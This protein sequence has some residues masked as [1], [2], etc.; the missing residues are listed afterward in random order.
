MSDLN[1]KALIEAFLQGQGFKDLDD[2]M[3][4]NRASAK[5][6]QDAVGQLGYSIENLQNTF[7]GLF[8]A[9]KVFSFL[10]DG[11]EGFART[12]RQWTGITAQIKALG[13]E[14]GSLSEN[15]RE[16][17]SS[18]SD[19]S[20]ILDDDLIPAFGRLLR[21]TDSVQSAQGF[22]KIASRF[23]ANGIG[24]VTTNAERLSIAFQTGTTKSLKD[25]GVQTVDAEGNATKFADAIKLIV[26]RANQFPKAADDAQAKID[27]WRKVMDDFG[28]SL[29]AVTNAILD[30]VIELNK[31]GGELDEITNKGYLDSI[32]TAEQKAADL[33]TEAIAS[34]LK[35]RRHEAAE[36]SL[37]AAVLREAK[38]RQ[39]QIDTA[40]AKAG[41]EQ[42]AKDA[43][44]AEARKVAAIKKLDQDYQTY[45]SGVHKNEE[46]STGDFFADI[47]R[48]AKQSASEQKKLYPDISKDW[49]KLQ[50]DITREAKQ[51]AKDRIDIAQREADLDLAAKQEILAASAGFV[52]AAFGQS[53]AAAIAEGGIHL[54][55]AILGITDK[56]AWNPA[57]EAVL[58]GL[59]SATY[60]AQIAQIE[61]AP[62]PSGFDDPVNDAL[63]ETFGQKW[64]AD[65]F[66]R[67]NSGF[68][69][70]L[71]KLDFSGGGGSTTVNN[72]RNSSFSPN[73]STT[74]N[75]RG[76]IFVRDTNGIKQFT[77]QQDEVRRR[78]L[79]RARISRA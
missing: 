17:I 23:A 43:I 39:R 36:E 9:S 10:K 78:I 49:E 61:S 28:D 45:L 11:F 34:N 57:V 26:D 79:M 2:A 4:K 72:T 21:A 18:L 59:A 65:L 25:F 48:A 47:L 51:G 71:A 31:Y 16:F 5:E 50:D 19:E 69:R 67:V 6:T 58:I 15:V 76:P 22:L 38:E 40:D 33:R 46:K 53:K 7:L 77:R 13:D 30:Q 27:T 24:D 1:V 63:A 62:S 37:I 60:A 68:E 12:E 29:S 32:K 64:A 52:S 70:S 56:W 54:A 73:Y 44:A 3:A 14:S 74:N 55:E 41:A 66:Y 75:F 20:G 35:S 8:A 42:Q